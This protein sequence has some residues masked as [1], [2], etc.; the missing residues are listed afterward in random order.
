MQVSEGTTLPF[1]KVSL[2]TLVMGITHNTLQHNGKS[3]KN[4]NQ[5]SI[6]YITGLSFSVFSVND[7]SVLYRYL[8]DRTLPYTK[9]FH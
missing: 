3:G 7:R 9:C 1:S 5:K 4:Y 8:S 6:L 2:G